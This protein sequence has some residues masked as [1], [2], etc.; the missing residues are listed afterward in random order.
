MTAL[1]IIG[2][3]IIGIICAIFGNIYV[4]INKFES[5]SS[6]G[7]VFALIVIWPVLIFIVTMVYCSKVIFNFISFISDLIIDK[8]EKK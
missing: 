1:I 4:T 5:Y 2:Y 3:F 6:S 8:W 7:I